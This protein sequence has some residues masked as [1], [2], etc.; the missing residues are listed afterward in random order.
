M[1]LEGV[2]PP[3]VR[4]KAACA[5]YCATSP[6]A[7]R[8][9]LCRFLRNCFSSLESGAPRVEQ[10]SGSYKEPALGRCATRR[11]MAA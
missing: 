9:R 10:G 1:G 8:V 7:C 4:L 5:S 11:R 3:I 6:C 2:E